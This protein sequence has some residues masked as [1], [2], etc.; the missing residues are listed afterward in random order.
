MG[1]WYAGRSSGVGKE[2]GQG[3]GT[4]VLGTGP[5]RQGEVKSAEEEGPACLPGTEPLCVADVDLMVRPDEDGMLGPLQPV[6]PLL[7]GRVDGQ[8]FLVPHV[9]ITLRR[10]EASG[11]EG[12]RVDEL[13]LL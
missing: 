9:I 13:V 12:D 11:Q 2:T 3:V 4:D 7:K 5:E 10:N 1:G 6:P 8:K